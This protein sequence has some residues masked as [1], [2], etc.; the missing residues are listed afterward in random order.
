MTDRGL[1]KGPERFTR[2]P[3]AA[4]S[5]DSGL[6]GT[7]QRGPVEGRDLPCGLKDDDFF[8]I[9]HV[10]MAQG[11]FCDCEILYN[12]APESRLRQQHWRAVADGRNPTIP[13]KAVTETMTRAKLVLGSY[14]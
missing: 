4:R 14:C 2:L 6:G 11:G 10:L 1:G 13:T 8:D 12:V 3:A 7:L 5:R 9:F